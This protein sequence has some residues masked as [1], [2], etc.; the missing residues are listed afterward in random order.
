MRG[1][2][3]G[4]EH[5]FPNNHLYRFVNVCGPFLVLGDFTIVNAVEVVPFFF[6]GGG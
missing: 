6:G 1:L 5:Q 2:F 4:F 3:G